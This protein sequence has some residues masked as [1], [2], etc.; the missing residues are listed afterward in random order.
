MTKRKKL[1]TKRE[2]RELHGPGPSGVLNGRQIEA[3]ERSAQQIDELRSSG[4]LGTPEE[5][6][7]AAKALADSGALDA[8][9]HGR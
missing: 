9:A 3:A 4:V 5:F 1:L 8:I 2:R 6:D 7:D